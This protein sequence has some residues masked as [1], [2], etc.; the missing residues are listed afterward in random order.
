M[1]GQNSNNSSIPKIPVQ[2]PT[3]KLFPAVCLSIP[4]TAT[5]ATKTTDMKTPTQLQTIAIQ[6][7]KPKTTTTRE[8]KRENHDKNGNKCYQHIKKS[9]MKGAVVT[10]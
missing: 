2:T 10:I 4:K 6:L 9:S 5:T 1:N 8:R 7:L 3:T